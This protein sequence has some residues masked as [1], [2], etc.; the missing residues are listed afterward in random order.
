MSALRLIASLV[1]LLVCADVFAQ[2]L[3][4]RR[5][6]H[7]PIGLNVFGSGVGWTT[8]DITLDPVLH[9][10]DGKVAMYTLG[11]NYVHSFELLGKS[12]RID[13]RLPYA[14][15]HWQGV[16]DGVHVSTRR[17]GFMDP[18]IGFAMNLYG[19]PPLKG[20]EFIAYRGSHPVNTIVGVALS[21]SPP[22]G[23][24]YPDRLINLGNN[25]WVIRPQLGVLHQR[26]PWQFEMTGTVVFY[27][28]NDDF[29]G[30]QTLE[31]DP[32]GFLELHAIRAFSRGRWASLSTGYSYGGETTINGRPS[33]ND[34]R[35]RYWALG[36]GMPISPSQSIKFTYVNADTNVYIGQSTN[37][38]LFSW[39]MNWSHGS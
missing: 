10:E 37:S 7:L 8:G 1:A 39:S 34:E 19:A 31:Q 22:W 33:H 25:H 18:R 27:Q 14:S 15:G 2:D 12:S 16:R 29:F 24:Y 26:G 13:F 28:D 38:L 9:I 32:L 21:M 11:A 36:H 35:T 5:W 17:Q 6:T 30:G 3:E 20:Q 4:P 23:E